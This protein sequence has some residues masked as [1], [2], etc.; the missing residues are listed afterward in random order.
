MKNQTLGDVDLWNALAVLSPNLTDRDQVQY[1]RGLLVGIVAGVMSR[2]RGK[3]RFDRAAKIINDHMPT[4][5]YK[6]TFPDGWEKHF[7]CEQI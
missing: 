6:G 5:V 3:N 1:C 7:D 4:K 2:M